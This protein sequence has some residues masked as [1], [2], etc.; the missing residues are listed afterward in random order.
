MCQWLVHF[1]NSCV[2]RG[3]MTTFSG[4]R[5]HWATFFNLEALLELCA[6]GLQEFLLSFLVSADLTLAG[7][8]M[9]S[10]LDKPRAACLHLMIPGN[11]VQLLGLIPS[12]ANAHHHV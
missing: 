11:K 9:S 8:H 10:R 7:R 3:V 2:H 12:Q 4:T 1:L 5:V 6:S